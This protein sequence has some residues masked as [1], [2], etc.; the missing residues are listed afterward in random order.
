MDPGYKAKNKELVNGYTKRTTGKFDHCENTTQ[1]TVVESYKLYYL[2][3]TVTDVPTVDNSLET[4]TGSEQ[5]SRSSEQLSSKHAMHDDS[6]NTNNRQ[7]IQDARNSGKSIKR[8]TT[9]AIDDADD[10]D[11]ALAYAYANNKAVMDR[12]FGFT[13]PLPGETPIIQGT[14]IAF[15]LHG[16]GTAKSMRIKQQY[17]D[18]EKQARLMPNDPFMGGSKFDEV[19][20]QARRE[21][22]SDHVASVVAKAMAGPTVEDKKRD[23]EEFHALIKMCQR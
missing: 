12:A 11:D 7:D 22:E 6:G 20:A 10:A 9:S 18:A 15:D 13:K 14:N 16:L 17:A 21:L 1:Q 3:V 19:L 5:S 8:E 23:D 4:V 2:K